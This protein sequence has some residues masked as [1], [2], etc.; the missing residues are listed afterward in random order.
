MLVTSFPFN[1]GQEI[2]MTTISRKFIV[3]VLLWVLSVSI[4]QSLLGIGGILN[5]IMRFVASP[6]LAIRIAWGFLRDSRR[7]FIKSVRR[8]PIK[9][10]LLVSLPITIILGMTEDHHTLLIF[11][12]G[13]IIVQMCGLLYLSFKWIFNPVK[14]IEKLSQALATTTTK[15]KII[16]GLATVKISKRTEATE[17]VVSHMTNL[18]K[19]IEASRGLF[20]YLSRPAPLFT[21]FL[22]VCIF[23]ALF[24]VLGVATIFRI[25]DQLSGTYAFSGPFFNGTISDYIYITAL[26]FTGSDLHG[27]TVQSA[28]IRYWL[29]YLPVMAVGLLTF[30][31]S[32]FS[33]IT[34]SRAEAA[35]ASISTE[36]DDMIS[37]AVKQISDKPTAIIIEEKKEK[38]ESLVST[39]NEVTIAKP[40]AEVLEET[41][42]NNEGS[43]N[44]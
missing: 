28:S 42:Q 32:G 41:N 10:L 3:L 21:I 25:Q 15:S 17:K 8:F 16:A 30:L 7:F 1:L 19:A 27:V 18:Q 5:G 40:K 11:I 23:D 38:K 9:T 29:V 36:V 4:C 26:Q 13:F 43:F 2:S 22:V 33:A 31:L 44:G 37:K 35:F 39:E 20:K 34:Q 24:A 14:P 12:R 6:L